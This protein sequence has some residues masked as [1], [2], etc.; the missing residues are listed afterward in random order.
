MGANRCSPLGFHHSERVFVVQPP[1]KPKRSNGFRDF[2]QI[3]EH[4]FDLG[5]EQA[6]AFWHDQ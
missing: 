1:Q 2:P 5:G 4:V 3:Y 6:Y